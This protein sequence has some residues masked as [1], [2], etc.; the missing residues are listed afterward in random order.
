M[1]SL[2]KALFDAGYSWLIDNGSRI[3]ITVFGTE[4][5]VN[6]ILR[7]YVKPVPNMQGYHVLT[8]NVSPHSCQLSSLD[9]GLFFE[10]RFGGKLASD[11][12]PWGSV[13][14]MFNPDNPEQMIQLPQK[15]IT[16]DGRSDEPA[17]P[18]KETKKPNPFS[19]ISG[20]KE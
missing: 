2:N 1:S 10:G 6:P 18:V 7:Q 17:E 9:E 11:T 13:I 16:A 8:L 20:G 15:L 4:I 12:F 5:T 19:V 14:Q 3:Y